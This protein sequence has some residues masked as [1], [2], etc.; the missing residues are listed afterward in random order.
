M[1]NPT[2]SNGDESEALVNLPSITTSRSV[3]SMARPPKFN[4]TLTIAPEERWALDYYAVTHNGYRTELADFYKALRGCSLLG[5]TITVRHILDVFKWFDDFASI[6]EDHNH[7][8]DLVVVPALREHLPEDQKE[9]VVGAE[10]EHEELQLKMMKFRSLAGMT[11]TPSDPIEI[12]KKM[13]AYGTEFLGC[14]LCA[15]SNEEQREAVLLES[16][17]DQDLID[18]LDLAKIEYIKSRHGL[19]RSATTGMSMVLC[20]GT[21]SEKQRTKSRY[22]RKWSHKAIYVL[23]GAKPWYAKHRALLAELHEIADAPSRSGAPS[24]LPELL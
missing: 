2:Q 1:C 16:H 10:A 9:L 4:F 5:T 8:E 15:M 12:A 6:F 21:E 19:L 11:D 23:A 20:W 3:V 7:F 13:I 18:K 22:L 24:L 14:A 17:C